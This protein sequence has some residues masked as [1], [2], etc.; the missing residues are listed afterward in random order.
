MTK[1][2]QHP[3]EQGPAFEKT[4]TLD[5]V[6]LMPGDAL[7]LQQ[8]VKGQHER[9]TVRVI[10]VM[11]PLSVLVTAPVVEGKL[12]F[13][14]EAQPF[15]VRAFSGL[16]VCAFKTHV[17]KTHHSPF[18]YLH[19][20]YPDS[21]EIMR[22]RKAV[23]AEVQLITAILDQEG[24][25]QIAAGRIVDLS[26]GGARIM[27]NNPFGEKDQIVFLSFKVKLDDIEEYIQTTAVIRAIGQEDD[28]HGQKVTVV[29]VQ[30]EALSQGNRLLI[31]HLVYQFLLKETDYAHLS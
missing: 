29:G 16:N 22:I 21:I 2:H 3:T 10:G 18:P 27:A 9:L 7:Q 14:R 13:I 30:F 23:R 25:K 1:S 8:M 17:L 24:G 19:L 28:E 5:E 11:K 31:M 6:K 15:L 26:V 4:G 20:A 12:I